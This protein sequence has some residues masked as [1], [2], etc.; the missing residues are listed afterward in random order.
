MQSCPPGGAR[1]T[2][3]YV[4]MSLVGHIS[5]QAQLQRADVGATTAT[6][7]MSADELLVDERGACHITQWHVNGKLNVTGWH[8][9]KY[10]MKFRIEGRM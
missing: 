5:Q 9:M 3:W 10:R 1:I 8:R 4:S 6:V 7:L 2:A